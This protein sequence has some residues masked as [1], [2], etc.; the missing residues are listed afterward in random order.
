MI[1]LW[2]ILWILAAILG[3]IL[4]I[5][6]LSAVPVK[7]VVNAKQAGKT[8]F[9]VRASWLFRFLRVE[10]S[11]FGQEEKFFVKILFFNVY[12]LKKKQKP[13]RPDRKKVRK[14]ARKKTAPEKKEPEV[15][16]KAQDVLTYGQLK[17]II[18]LALG[19]AKKIAK[20]LRPKKFEVTGIIGFSCPYQTGMFFA[21]Y[22]TV[23]GIFPLRK[24]IDL[25]GEFNTDETV[26]RL[27][28]DIRGKIN[29]FRITVPVVALLLKKPVRNLIKKL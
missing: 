18:K 28:A 9:S 22:E 20:R 12:S 8:E 13:P 10:Y 3:L 21:A 11:N 24:N 16:A 26:I 29:I 19:T 14:K 4:L 23:A 27:D 25:T 7:Y 17:T 1:V 15:L 2:I 5:V 6:A